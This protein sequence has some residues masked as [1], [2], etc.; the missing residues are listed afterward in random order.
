ML[1]ARKIYGL[2]I[3]DINF[4]IDGDFSLLQLVTK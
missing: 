1:N 3:N 4:M 2:Q